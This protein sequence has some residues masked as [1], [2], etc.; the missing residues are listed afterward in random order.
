MTAM[1]LMVLAALLTLAVP[2]V[3]AR[4]LSEG[5]ERLMRALRPASGH[6]GAAPNLDALGISRT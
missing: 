1:C 5:V 6:P 4:F 3:R 2:A